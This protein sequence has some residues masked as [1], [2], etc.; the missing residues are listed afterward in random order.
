MQ[1]SRAIGGA[2]V[3]QRLIP[4]AIRRRFLRLIYGEH[5][6]DKSRTASHQSHDDKACRAAFMYVRQQPVIRGCVYVFMC[7]RGRE[8]N[9]DSRCVCVCVTDR[10]LC[11]CVCVCVCVC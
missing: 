10:R 2:I 6:I 1:I 9:P 11:V 8:G 5:R 3:F 7:L 4:P